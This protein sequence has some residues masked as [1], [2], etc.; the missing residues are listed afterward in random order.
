MIYSDRHYWK[1]SQWLQP[2]LMTLERLRWEKSLRPG[3]PGPSEEHSE[4]HLFIQTASHTAW[5]LL[6]LPPSPQ[7]MV[8]QA[9]ASMPS[10]KIIQGKKVLRKLTM[11]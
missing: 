11:Q 4:S 6:I 10:F 2:I 8:L 1:P 7:E 3:V 5:E 9:W